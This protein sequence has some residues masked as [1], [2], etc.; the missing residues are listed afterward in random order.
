[1][2]KLFLITIAYVALFAAIVLLYG[3]KVSGGVMGSLSDVVIAFFTLLISY[4][5]TLLVV[6]A[7][8]WR[9]QQE[10]QAGSEFLSKFI[11][12]YFQLIECRRQEVLIYRVIDELLCIQEKNGDGIYDEQIN[13]LLSTKKEVKENFKK[14]LLKLNSHIEDAA[15]NSFL[16]GS[17]TDILELMYDSQLIRCDFHSKLSP[18]FEVLSKACIRQTM[19]LPKTREIE[20]ISEY[21]DIVFETMFGNLQKIQDLP[22]HEKADYTFDVKKWAKFKL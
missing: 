15:K 21:K 1:M 12:F 13:K 20:Y 18:A 3:Y 22:E 14:S 17:S 16:F 2:K 19:Q 10:Y 4:S 7:N 5:T 11:A 6:A 8:S 9:E